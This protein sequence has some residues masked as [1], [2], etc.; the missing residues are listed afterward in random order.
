MKTFTL[1]DGNVVPTFGLGTWKSKPGEV[2]EA[3]KEALKVGYRH[4][5][6]AWIYQNEA[7]VGQ[8]IRACVEAGVLKREDLFVTSKLWNTF[9][10]PEAVEKGCQET[11]TALGLDYL[12]LYLMHWPIAF[13]PDKSLNCPSQKHLRQ[14]L[15]C[16]TKVWSKASASQTAGFLL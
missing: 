6:A 2:A 8:G 16:V 14:C 10:A 9:H 11:L 15:S 7:E 12:N 1:N 13:R 3:V 5:D 4:I